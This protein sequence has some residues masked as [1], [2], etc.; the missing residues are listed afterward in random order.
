MQT[1][2]NASILVSKFDFRI[3]IQFQMQILKFKITYFKI[4]NIKLIYAYVPLVTKVLFKLHLLHCTKH[5]IL[6]QWKIF[7]INVITSC[8]YIY[9]FIY[10]LY[11]YLW[12][13]LLI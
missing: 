10:L 13:I 6:M 4:H 9:L 5:L 3:R 8:C 7:T 12:L 1:L 2:V 11:T